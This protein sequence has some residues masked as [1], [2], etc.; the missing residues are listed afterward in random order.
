MGDDNIEIVNDGTNSPLSYNNNGNLLNQSNKLHI[1]YTILGDT[2]SKKLAIGNVSFSN[3]N[4]DATLEILP[5][6]ATDTG[7]IVQVP[8]ISECYLA[9]MA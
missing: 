8:H 2:S 6:A 4:P 3:I 1:G 7:L 5:N 9:G